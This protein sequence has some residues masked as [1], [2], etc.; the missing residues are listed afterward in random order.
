MTERKAI[1]ISR[2]GNYHCTHCGAHDYFNCCE[3]SSSKNPA[4]S[5]I[6]FCPYCGA[7]FTHTVEVDDL[8]GYEGWDDG[9]DRA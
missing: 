5:V 7:R 8:D 3:N 9:D 1:C 4:M 2:E 6:K